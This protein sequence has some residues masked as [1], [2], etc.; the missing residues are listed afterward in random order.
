[1][2]SIRIAAAL[3]VVTLSQAAVAGAAE[4]PL[5]VVVS[6]PPLAMIVSELGGDR[7]VVRSILP[8]GADPHTFEPK[9]SDAAAVAAAHIVISL[10]SAI[11]DWLGDTLDAPDGAIVVRLDAAPAE[12]AASHDH[13]RDPHV[14]LDPSWVRDHAISPI[15]R[16]LAEADPEGAPRYGVTAR[17]MSEALADLETEV[18]GAFALASTRSFLAWHPA[19]NRF[20]ERFDLH[21][22]GSLGESEGREPSLRAMID[23]VRAGRAAGVRAVLVEPQIDPRQARVLAGE[24]G[25]PL[26]T[27]DPLGGAWGLERATYASLILFNVHAFQ[28]ALAVSLPKEAPPVSPIPEKPVRRQ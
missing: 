8:A 11:D 16:A 2:R 24:L 19:W 25:V 1:M 22:V 12:S 23:A 21:P 13:E 18:R 5:H 4:L 14:W 27:V 3:A 17:A 28:Q 6:I 10:G 9:P 26:V 20:A 7:V 15:Y